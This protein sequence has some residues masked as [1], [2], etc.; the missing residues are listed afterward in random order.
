MRAWAPGGARAGVALVVLAA[1]VVYAFTDDT[2]VSNTCYLGVLVGAAVGA[3]IGAERRAPGRRLVP[4]LVAGGLTLN[5]LGDVV[6]TVL[7]LRGEDTDVSL[8]DPAWFASYVLLCLALWV[9][10]TRTRPRDTGVDVD[11]LVDAATVA[12]VSLLL[13]WSLSIES[14]VADP[15]STP[16]EATVAASYPVADAVLVA[17]VLRVLVSR[18]A[19]A[20]VGTPFAVGVFLWLASDIVFLQTPGDAVSVLMDSGWMLGAAL[21]AQAAWRPDAAPARPVSGVN[22]TGRFVQMTVAVGPLMVPPA[23]ELAADLRDEPDQPVQLLVGTAALIALAVVRT[24]RLMRSEERAY[25]ELEVAR[26]AA[27]EASRAKSMFLA[28]VSHEIR[29]PLTTMLAVAELLED[30]DPSRVQ[31]TLLT[32]L[33]RSGAQLLGLVEEILDFS[34][35]ESGQV[36]LTS[37]PFELREVVAST[38]SGYGPRASS[39]G[40]GLDWRIDPGLPHSVLGDCGRLTQVLTNLLDN[41]LKFTHEGTVRLTVRPAAAVGDETSRADVE[42]VVSDTGIGISPEDQLSVFEAFRQVDG[43]TTR[44]YNGTGLGLAIGK[45]L[46]T[47]MGG[48]L[49]VQSQLGAGTSF[50]A[51]IPLVPTP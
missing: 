44:R 26:D 48:T 10:L 42:F 51:R 2:V 38:V 47:L 5:A 19:R 28:N 43:S 29:T 14:I 3:W 12:V 32:K 37:A 33:D 13:F 34:R 17:L 46:T 45:D 8:A 40:I 41:A 27:L 25:H 20:G 36:V 11:F 18:R 39:A 49:T 7:D 23:L 6:W 1:V 15:T 9:V 22:R 24:A 30:T 21:M 35:I 31:T 16:F 4:R 50:V